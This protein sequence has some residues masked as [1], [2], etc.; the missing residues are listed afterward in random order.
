MRVAS[1]A[2]RRRAIRVALRLGVLMLA[3][4]GQAREVE[5][6]L[7]VVLRAFG[8]S[9]ADAVVSYS[10]VAVSFVS[11]R[12]ADATTAIQAVRRWKPDF[13]L[14]NAAA[15]LVRAIRDGR[16]DLEAAEAELD[17]LEASKHPYPRWLVYAA[18]ALLS[19]AVTI[20]FGGSVGDALVTLAIGLAIQPAMQKIERSELASFFQ[21]VFGVSATALLVVLLVK[22]GLPMQ[23]GLVLT[24]SLLRFL[25]GADLVSGMHDLISG[26]FMSGLARLAEVVLLGVA[27]A[28]AASLVLAF[29]GGIGVYLRITTTGFVGWPP[30]ALVA[31]GSVAVAFYGVRVGVPWRAL[32]A[33]C[34]LGAAAVVLARGLIPVSRELLPDARTLIA[35]LL[36]GA[37]G[38]LLGH[39]IEAPPALWTVPAI[40]PLLPAPSTLLPLL[41]D[42]E[43]TRQ[44]LQGQAAATAFVIGVGTASGSILVESYLRYRARVLKPVAGVLSRRLGR[45]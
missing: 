10:T 12:D 42:T 44:A 2:G 32:P 22:L 17:R 41:A 7:L 34:A 23:G 20:L 37:V 19:M 3:S 1:P 9:G 38:T 18:P 16:V 35:A 33:A 24:G 27:I 31:A 13:D 40:L 6:S 4:G 15:A 14:L 43:A 5:T 29:G 45:H 36:I 26:S 21:V 30:L 39:R 8:L 28:G 25:P 11:G